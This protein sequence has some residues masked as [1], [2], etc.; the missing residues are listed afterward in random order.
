MSDITIYGIKNC[1]TMKKAFDWLNEK[2][3]S[4]HFHN[5]KTDGL[6]LD[7]INEWLTQSKA[8]ILINKAGTTF[9]ALPEEQKENYTKKPTARKI[10]SGNQSVIKRP[11]LEKEGKIIA[12]GFK[13]DL[14]EQLFFG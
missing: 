4:Y 1:D 5:Y 3:I 11:V 10:M 8:E 9:K 7:K 14:Y 2:G 6:N 12:I 13:P